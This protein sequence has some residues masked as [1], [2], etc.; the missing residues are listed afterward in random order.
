MSQEWDLLETEKGARLSSF[1]EPVIPKKD[2]PYSILKQSHVLHPQGT[3]QPLTPEFL[4]S[5][6]EK[7]PDH[8]LAHGRG[9]GC[10]L[11]LSDYS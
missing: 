1:D 11:E 5:Q 4:A 2:P 6:R 9:F 10:G 8:V 7:P 3:R